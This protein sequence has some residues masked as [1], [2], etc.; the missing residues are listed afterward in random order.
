MKKSNFALRL[1]PS[2][3]DEARRIAED[4]G[5]AVNQLINVAVA[6]KIAVLRTQQDYFEERRARGD[7]NKALRILERAGVGNP[8]VAGDELPTAGQSRRPTSNEVKDRTRRSGR[9][10]NAAATT[11]DKQLRFAI[12][13]RRLIEVRYN[14]NVRVVEPHDYGIHNG[15][16]RLLAYQH[17]VTARTPGRRHSG[18]RLFDVAK[19]DALVVL[20]ESFKGS[21]GGSHNDHMAWDVVYQR[22]D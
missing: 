4:E 12:A 16:P 8:P 2:L 15:I 19:I 21:R 5:V 17:R 10:V 13:H 11:L 9:N 18:W 7:V 1:Q 3:M 20:D 22:V 6:E 14:N